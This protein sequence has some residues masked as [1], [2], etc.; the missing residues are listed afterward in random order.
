LVVAPQDGH[1]IRSVPSS[2][3]EP[4]TTN[5]VRQAEHRAAREGPDERVTVASSK[6][7][8]SC[9]RTHATS[10]AWTGVR[11]RKQRTINSTIGRS[12]LALERVSE[13]LAPDTPP[14]SLFPEKMPN[15]GPLRQDR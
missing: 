7:P 3:R 8:T 15:F 12:P 6:G 2:F 5:G 9:P 11:Q 14:C 13:I 10:P 4:A 1:A